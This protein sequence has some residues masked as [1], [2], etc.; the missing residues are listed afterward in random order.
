MT[1]PKIPVE[2]IFLLFWAVIVAIMI[3]AK[4]FLV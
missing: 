2:L 3:L 4:I 1:K